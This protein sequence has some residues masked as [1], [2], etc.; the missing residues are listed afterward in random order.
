MGKTIRLIINIII[1][2]VVIGFVAY[3]VNS[4]NKDEH[5]PVSTVV[6]E[7]FTSPV[8]R[9]KTLEFPF[10]IKHFD[11]YANKIFLTDTQ[12]VFVYQGNGEKL[13][14]FPVQSG[15][16]DI[17]VNGDA[18]FMLYPTSVDVYS[19]EGDSINHWEACSGLSDYCAMALTGNFVFVTDAQNKNICKYTKEGKFVKFIFSPHDFIIPGYSFDIFNH[20]DTIYCVNSGRHL[21]ESYTLDGDFIASFGGAGTGSG[22]FAGCCNPAYISITGEGKIFTSEKGNPRVS[23]FQKNGQFEK[24]LLNNQLLGG[25]YHACEIGVGNDRLF[26]AVKDRIDIYG[27][28]N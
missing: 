5:T 27:F 13:S 15:V 10:E 11:L 14:S 20:N 23:S 25:G 9:I 28:K 8:E 12:T 4:V 19:S 21:I 22:F 17:A 7:A 1:F 6:Q 26:V 16:R 3:I 2:I 18:I 24:V